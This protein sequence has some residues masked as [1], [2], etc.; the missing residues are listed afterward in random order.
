MSLQINLAVV[1]HDYVGIF[2]PAETGIVYSNQVGGTA[3]QHPRME[4]FFVL[5]S[6]GA[7][8]QDPFLDYSLSRYSTDHQEMV[9]AL[10][11][12]L[13]LDQDLEAPEPTECT[14]G[15]PEMIGE[16]WIPVK[17]KTDG[18]GWHSRSYGPLANLHGRVGI[19]TY[20]NSD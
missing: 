11:R 14:G 6:A 17:V 3:C 2:F 4:G 8:E 19:L 20:P 1:D 10:L 15:D 9:N 16:A 12:E 18:N 7:S 13:G 5:L